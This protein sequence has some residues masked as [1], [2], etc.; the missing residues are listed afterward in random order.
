MSDYIIDPQRGPHIRDYS[1]LSQ[2]RVIIYGHT[3]YWA[4]SGCGYTTSQMAGVYTRDDA[5]KRAG[6]CGPEKGCCFYDVPADHVPTLQAEVERLREALTEARCWIP[7][8]SRT[9]PM[10]RGAKCDTFSEARWLMTTALAAT[11]PKE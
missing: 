3:G 8:G 7:D 5:Y 10:D 6:H 2:D 4:P 9:T 1:D 11:A